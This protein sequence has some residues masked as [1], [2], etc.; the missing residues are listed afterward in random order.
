MSKKFYLDTNILLSLLI[1]R[2]DKQKECLKLVEKIKQ[3]KINAVTGNIVLAELVWV[4]KSYY[5]IPKKEISEKLRGITRLRGL[6]IIDDYDLSRAIDIYEKKSL[7]YIDALIA[8]TKLVNLKKWVVVS[9][10]KDF[11]KIGV[12][13]KEPADI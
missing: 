11:D 12:L 9:F 13:R 8:S 10:N 6:K 1:E 7:K 4:L 3:N 2:D 5:G